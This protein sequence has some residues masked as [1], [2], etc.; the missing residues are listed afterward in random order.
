MTSTPSDKRPVFFFDID[1]RFF[2]VPSSFAMMTDS[3]SELSLLERQGRAFAH[4]KTNQRL[5]RQ[6]SRTFE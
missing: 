3:Y 5:L 4:G 6:A 2:S 1:V